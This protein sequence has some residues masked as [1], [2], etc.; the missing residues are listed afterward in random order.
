MG[1]DAGFNMVIR[2]Q[3]T[4]NVCKISESVHEDMHFADSLSQ[5]PMCQAM[6]GGA[7]GAGL[8]ILMMMR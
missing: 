7:L 3:V 8:I 4:T 1:K 6:E 2:K 5:C